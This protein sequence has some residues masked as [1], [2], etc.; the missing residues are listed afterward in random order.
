MNENNDNALTRRGRY[1]QYLQ[2][3]DVPL[4]ESTIHSRRKREQVTLQV[5]L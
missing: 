4:P 3:D 2:D 1:K 5:S